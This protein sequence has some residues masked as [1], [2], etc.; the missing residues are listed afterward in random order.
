M[1]VNIDLPVKEKELRELH[2]GDIIYLN[3]LIITARDQAHKKII[4]LNEKGNLPNSLKNLEGSAIYHCG[5]IIR[6]NKG[7]YEF[8]SGGPTTSQRMNSFENEVIDILKVK[9]II[10]KGGMRTLNT[11]NYRV[12][13][14]SLTGGCGAIIQKKVKKIVNVELKNLGICEAIWFLEIENLGPLIVSQI[15]EKSLY[16]KEF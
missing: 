7:D 9:F 5:P 16:D 10:G 11:K 12:I 2:L 13:Y 1:R 6:E 14:L 15:N 4:Q 3:G 8:I